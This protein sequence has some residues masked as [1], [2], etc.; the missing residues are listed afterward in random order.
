[1]GNRPEDLTRKEEEEEESYV[2]VFKFP[3]GVWV[4]IVC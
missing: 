3:I 1:M 2:N 4:L